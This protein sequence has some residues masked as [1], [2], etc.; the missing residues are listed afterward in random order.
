VDAA[1]LISH[2]LPLERAVDEGFALLADRGADPVLKV[3]VS[4]RALD[5]RA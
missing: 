2:R 1:A 3:L 4:P 5:M